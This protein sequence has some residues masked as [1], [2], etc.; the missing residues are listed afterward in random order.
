MFRQAC[1]R[2]ASVMR[3]ATRWLSAVLL[4]TAVSAVVAQEA[5]I[6]GELIRDPTQPAH[7]AITGPADS[8]AG[9]LMQVPDRSLYALSFIRTGGDYPI[10]VINDQSLSIGDRVGDAL[11]R[12]IRPTEVILAIGGRELV[13]STISLPVRESVN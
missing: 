8:P 7:L 6:D 11:V 1:Q 9:A 2:V 4:A 5:F 12:D 3:K 13:L 10:A